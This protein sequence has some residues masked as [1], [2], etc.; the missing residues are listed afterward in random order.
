[1]QWILATSSPEVALPCDAGDI[2]A[3]RRMPESDE[4]RLYDGEQA[5]VH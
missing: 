4:V 2:L 5:L 3:L 1:V